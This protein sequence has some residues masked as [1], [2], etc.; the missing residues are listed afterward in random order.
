MSYSVSST[1]LYSLAIDLNIDYYKKTKFYIRNKRMKIKVFGL[2]QYTT[3]RYAL[4]R[5]CMLRFM[6]ICVYRIYYR[7]VI[8]AVDQFSISIRIHPCTYTFVRMHAYRTAHI[9]QSQLTFV[10]NSSIWR[11]VSS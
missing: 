3:H 8:C 4:P 11:L 6:C 2:G 9:M 7:Y 5:L 10:W 1:P